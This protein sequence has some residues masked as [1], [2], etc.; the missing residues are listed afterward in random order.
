MTHKCDIDMVIAK[1]QI[2]EFDRFEFTDII[3][4]ETEGY[5][6]IHKAS[7][8]GIDYALK[9]VKNFKFADLN[10]EA[11]ALEVRKSKSGVFLFLFLFLFLSFFSFFSFFIYISQF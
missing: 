1:E 9:C 4:V 10:T 7:R 2:P 5:H 3:Q 11:F 8:L 6:T